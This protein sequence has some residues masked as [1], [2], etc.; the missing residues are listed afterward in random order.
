[1]KS[2]TL[3]VSYLWKDTWKRWLE[4]PSSPLARF[5]VT[6][7][8][9]LVA[10]AILISFHLLERSLHARLE[11]FGLNT[12]IL[13]ETIAPD[14]LQLFTQGEGPDAF[15]SLADHGEKIRLRQLFVRAQSEWQNNMMVMSYPP[16]ALGALAPYLST[17]TP[18]LC[19]SETLPEGA[20]MRFTID[21]HSELACVRRPAGWL[22]PLVTEDVLV[23]PEGMFR[24]TERMGYI[25]TTV[26]QRATNAPSIAQTIGAIQALATLEHHSPP[27]IQSALPLAQ[28]WEALKARQTQWRNVLAAV[29]G[30]SLALVFG[31]IGVLEFRQ[32]LYVSA[33]LRSFGTPRVFLY[34]RHWLENMLLANGAALS[35]IGLLAALHPMIFSTLGVGSTLLDF[36]Q[37]NPYLSPEVLSIFLWINLGALLSSVPIALGLRQ[38]VGT[39]L[40]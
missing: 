20:L 38:P 5:A 1:M 19:L 15:A 25:E 12:L 37:A 7:L 30:L 34:A 6:A 35:A 16:S 36:S 40:S 22:R 11:R 18:V 28:S 14:S 23:A 13:R 4:Q 9:V 33:L 26:Y 31:A 3:I 32:N 8:L 21:R 17:N 27:Q 10:T 2:S 29:L 39:T 24:S